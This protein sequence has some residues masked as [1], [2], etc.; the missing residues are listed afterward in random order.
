MNEC[1]VPKRVNLH[2]G[3][4]GYVETRWRRLR[5]EFHAMC[6]DRIEI[7]PPYEAA[8]FC[9]HRTGSR[10]VDLRGRIYADQSKQY[11]MWETC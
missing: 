7:E 1:T 6:I 8:D 5:V 9:L 2:F 11:G 4:V 3:D 10:I